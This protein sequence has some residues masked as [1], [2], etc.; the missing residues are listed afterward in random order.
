[1]DRFSPI[2]NRNPLP[3]QQTVEAWRTI[4]FI[5]LGIF[6]LEA[7]TFLALGSGEEQPWARPQ[8]QQQAADDVQLPLTD[9][10]NKE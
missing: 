1:M 3:P 5:T 10:D 6:S 2:V 9:K 8:Q 4:F 7:V